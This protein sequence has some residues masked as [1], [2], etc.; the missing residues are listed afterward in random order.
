MIEYSDVRNALDSGLRASEAGLV[1][2]GSTWRVSTPQLIWILHLDRLPYGHQFGVDLG[3]HIKGLGG[4]TASLRPTD[5]PI[6]LH[7][8]NIPLSDGL[9]R[10]EIVRSLDLDA[11]MPDE[12]RRLTIERVGSVLGAFVQSHGTLQDL[13]TA[14]AEGALASAFIRKDARTLLSEN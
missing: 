3:V 12:D 14:Y 9:E 7:L 11:D 13:R 2:S 10:T 8:E 5:C 4:S 6:L 1:G